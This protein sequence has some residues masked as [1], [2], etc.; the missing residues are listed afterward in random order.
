MERTA[1][2]SHLSFKILNLEFAVSTIFQL[3]P[4]AP[5]ETEGL[6]EQQSKETGK[7]F[8]KTTILESKDHPS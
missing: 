7:T 4:D 5:Y 6:P 8:L 1:V 2:V 3:F